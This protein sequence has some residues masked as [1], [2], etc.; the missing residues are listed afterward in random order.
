MSTTIKDPLIEL[1]AIKL[2]EHDLVGGEGSILGWIASDRDWPGWAALEED[3]RELYRRMARGET[4]M[5]APR[6]FEPQPRG[7]SLAVQRGD[8]P[9]VDPLDGHAMKR[10]DEPSF[11]LLGRDPLAPF[12]VSIWSSLRYGDPQAARVKFEKLLSTFAMPYAYSPDVTR[13]SRALDVA[14]SMFRYQND[15]GMKR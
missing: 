8:V 13:A 12:L 4:P 7:D 2:Y 10:P 5:F 15:G 9:P 14:M 6:Q 11:T 1:L 3:D